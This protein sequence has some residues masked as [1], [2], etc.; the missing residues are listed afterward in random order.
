MIYQPGKNGAPSYEDM[1]EAI[2]YVV[3]AVLWLVFFGVPITAMIL[4][5]LLGLP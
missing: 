2:Y 4:L 3:L 5:P 1:G